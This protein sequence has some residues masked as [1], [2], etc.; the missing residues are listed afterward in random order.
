MGNQDG[1]KPVCA[2]K[3]ENIVQDIEELKTQHRTDINEIH[4]RHDKS[5][6]WIHDIKEAIVKLTL[7]QE[8]QQKSIDS[9]SHALS[10]QTDTQ[11]KILQRILDNQQSKGVMSTKKVVAIAGIMSTLIATIGTIVVAMLS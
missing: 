10:K 9:N 2:E 11:N 7:I 3:F 4:E 8:N 1:V 5:F 6:D